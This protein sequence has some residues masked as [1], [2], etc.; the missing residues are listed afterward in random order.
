VTSRS[1]SLC[2]LH[3]TFDGEFVAVTRYATK[4]TLRLFLFLFDIAAL[5]ILAT[6][7]LVYRASLDM[8]LLRKSCG[9]YGARLNLS[10]ALTHSSCILPFAR[11]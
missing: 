9:A 10:T 3:V 8:L 2:F 4:V 1:V 7:L 6:S 11:S 5:G